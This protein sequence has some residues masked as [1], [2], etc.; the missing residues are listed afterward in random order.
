MGID[1]GWLGQRLSRHVWGVAP[2]TIGLNGARVGD[3]TIGE[4]GFCFGER[5]KIWRLAPE[6][7]VEDAVVDGFADVLGQDLRAAVEVGDRARYA[8]DL[9]VGAG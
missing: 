8:K 3:S 1:F 9:V 4:G 7:A 6:L 5:G 2:A